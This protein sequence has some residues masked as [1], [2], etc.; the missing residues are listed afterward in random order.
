MLNRKRKNKVENVVNVHSDMAAARRIAHGKF[1]LQ[2]LQDRNH[3]DESIQVDEIV[4]KIVNV[5]EKRKI[6]ILG[7]MKPN[8]HRLGHKTLL[9]SLHCVHKLAI[10]HLS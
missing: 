6:H 7:N 8:A 3:L 10:L 1:H 4:V 5:L 9:E 2:H